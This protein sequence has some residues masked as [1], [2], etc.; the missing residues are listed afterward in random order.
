MASIIHTGVSNNEKCQLET[1]SF[2]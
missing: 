1:L 2:G